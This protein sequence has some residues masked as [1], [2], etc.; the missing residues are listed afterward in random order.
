M[1]GKD[2]IE[3]ISRARCSCQCCLGLDEGGFVGFNQSCVLSGRDIDPAAVEVH[4]RIAQAL[5]LSLD[6]VISFNLERL[7]RSVQPS[8][9]VERSVKALDKCLLHSIDLL[10]H[11]AAASSPGRP[12]FT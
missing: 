3:T 6:S 8:S 11:A 7:V 2:D 4:W 5:L 10:A 12:I 9:M 1:V